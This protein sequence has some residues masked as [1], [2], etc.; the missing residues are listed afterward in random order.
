[1]TS[2]INKNYKKIGKNSIFYEINQKI[3]QFLEKY[4]SSDIISLGIGDVTRPYSKTLVE[5]MTDAIKQQEKSSTFLGY[6][7]EDGYLFLRFAIKNYYKNFN[8][9]LC[10]SEIFVSNGISCDIANI[11]NIFD[12]YTPLIIEPT[13][14]AYKTANL[15]L[16]KKPLI[17]CATDQNSYKVLP[18]NIPQK[19]YVIYLCSPNNPTGFTYSFSDLKLWVDFAI[20][21]NSVILFD[22]AYEFFIE[23]NYPHSIF[24]VSNAKNCAIEFASFSK[25]AGFTNLRCGY[26]IIPKSLKRDGVF[27]CQ[28]FLKR[29]TTCF[30]GVPYLV[31]K[32][33]EYVLTKKGLQEQKQN[34]QYYKQNVKIIAKYMKKLNFECIFSKNS[35]YLWLKCPNEKTSWEFFDELLL[36]CKVVCVPGVAFGDCGEGYVRLSGF[37]SHKLT[38]KA[39]QRIFDYYNE[40]GTT[41]S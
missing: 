32:G 2:F 15:F 11:L 41:K 36:C 19:Q 12:S 33:A 7:P 13:Y 25:M 16:G 28:S 14:P 39:C 38:Q 20:K 22:S 24:E 3:S 40:K 9:E 35:P 10:D 27:L 4:P 17:L 21:T 37:N 6:P 29:Q 31:Q 8:V 30:N 5:V 26:T 1:M 18:Q 23:G 34:I